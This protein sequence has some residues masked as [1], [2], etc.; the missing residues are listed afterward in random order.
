MKTAEQRKTHDHHRQ[1]LTEAEAAAS[2]KE[3]GANL[4]TTAAPKSFWRLFIGNLG[5]PVIRILLCALVIHLFFVF[6]GGDWVE[7]VGIAISVFL[8]ALIST[9]SERGSEAAFRRLSEECDRSE[10]RVL[11]DGVWRQ[12]G[13]EEI[14]VGDVIRLSA[15]EQIPADGYVIRGTL[16]VDQSAMTGENREVEKCP[17]ADRSKNPNGRSAVLRGCPILTGEADVLVFSVGD[18][19]FL[20]QIS[21]ELRMETRESPLKLR[22]TKLA[23]QISRL[24]YCAAALVALAYLFHV[25]WMD[26]GFEP[27]A[28]AMKLRDLSFLGHHLLEA[29]MMGLTVVVLTVPEGLPLMISVVLSANIRR[30]TRDQVLVRKPVGIEAAGSMNLLFTDKTGTLTEG[31][32]S[33]CSILSADGKEFSSY[34][35]LRRKAPALA[36]LYD[37]SCRYNTDAL[38]S[39]GKILGGNATDRAM[40]ASVPQ[41][42]ESTW[43]IVSRLPFDSSRKYA[44]VALRKGVRGRLCLIK[45]A[46]ELL[47]PSVRYAYVGEGRVVEFSPFSFAFLR[48]I[49]EMTARG[50][51]VLLLA[52][53]DGA[54]RD[55]FGALTL[56]AAV[57]LRDRIRPEARGAVTQLR[58]AG[59]GV[60]MIT[61]DH[62]ATARSIA[63]ECGLLT[64]SRNLVLTGEELSG[65]SDAE[66]S[67]RIPHL[68]AVAR[69]LPSDK[70]RLVRLAQERELVVGMTGDGVNDA[71]AL[72]RAD[73]GFAMGSGTRVARDA[74]DIVILD[75]N[76][77][78]IARAV[79]YGRTIFKSIRKFI[80]LQLTMNFCAVGVSMIGPFVGFSAPV[81]VVQMLW[82]NIIMDTLGGLAFAGEAPMASTMKEKPKK[83]DE[84]ILNGY[85]IDQILFLGS[86]TV[87]LCMTFLLHPTLRALFRETP[88]RLCHLTAFFAL[89]IFTSVFN[90]FNARTDRL[91]LFA[92]VLRNRMFLGIMFLIG[93][94]QILF[95]YLGGSVLRTMPLLPRELWQTLALSLIVFPA[96]WIRKLIWR[97][98][99][100]S[101]GF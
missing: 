78:S 96:E 64:R 58:E 7:T 88:D 26:S 11:R 3:H 94:V 89:F 38:W 56:I 52:E 101:G 66:L 16:G 49:E 77:S 40:L 54:E 35:D 36:E 99:G 12:I 85:M 57:L 48:K 93:V 44:M 100:K 69:A 37:V 98:R 25:F 79:L 46:P 68:A 87:G 28:V 42:G 6:R 90:C 70:S 32:M 1:G 74:G 59:V 41:T 29:F 27:H 17:S 19:T 4:L 20:G 9:L 75:N 91:R 47:L 61:G 45:G 30:M 39:E 84:A 50:G 95:I 97:L 5:D 65:L 63:E 72:K 43:E 14:V 18:A 10:I 62:P 13:M 34:G 51:R 80:T 76:L 71:P 92:G 81:T 24:G 23:K 73:V 83:R 67:E 33:V 2:R 82:I 22:L 55:S 31:K 15:G 21:G 53:G 60:I 86:V 8:A